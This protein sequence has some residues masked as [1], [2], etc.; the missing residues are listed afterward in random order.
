MYRS[1]SGNYLPHAEV[2]WSFVYGHEFCVQVVIMTVPK[3][4]LTRSDESQGR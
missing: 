1:S 4:D 2:I 3:F